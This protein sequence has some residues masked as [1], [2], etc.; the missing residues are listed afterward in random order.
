MTSASRT[1][2]CTIVDNLSDES[3]DDFWRRMKDNNEVYLEDQ[4]GNRDNAE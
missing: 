2:Y 4:D 1:T 3:V